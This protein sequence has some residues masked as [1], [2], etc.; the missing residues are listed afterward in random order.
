M[1]DRYN[2]E[3]LGEEGRTILKLLFKTYDGA[4][5]GLVGLSI[6]TSVWLL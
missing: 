1:K 5:T 2:L 6:G 3:D 4:W